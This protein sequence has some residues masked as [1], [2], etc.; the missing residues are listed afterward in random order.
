MVRFL[1]GLLALYLEGRNKKE[2]IE[3]RRDNRERRG[4]GGVC[5]RE[6]LDQTRIVVSGSIEFQ[7]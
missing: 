6:K 3:E 5:E 7:H 4:G 2:E 1:C